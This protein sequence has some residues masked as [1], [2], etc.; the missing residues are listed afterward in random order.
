MKYIK[1]YESNIKDTYIIGNDSL[2]ISD[3]MDYLKVS[4]K[5]KS[6][7]IITPR[8]QTLTPYS[9]YDINVIDFFKEIFIGKNIIAKIFLTS[10]DIDNNMFAPI[11]NTGHFVRGIVEDIDKTTID[12][13]LYLT[14]KLSSQK[15]RVTIDNNTLIFVWPYDAKDK[16]L[17]TQ[18]SILKETEKYNL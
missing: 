14:F 15:D 17:H 2:F 11:E 1:K 10:D 9:K 8:Y 4:F 18:V 7:P 3:V 16:P 12:N 5:Y 6:H 13:Q